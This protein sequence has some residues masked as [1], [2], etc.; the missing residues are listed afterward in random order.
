[1]PVPKIP[2][3]V[4]C[5][6]LNSDDRHFWLT[7]KVRKWQKQTREEWRKCKERSVVDMDGEFEETFILDFDGRSTVM[8]NYATYNATWMKGFFKNPF[9]I[10]WLN[11]DKYDVQMVTYAWV[12]LETMSEQVAMWELDDDT[13][14]SL[15]FICFKNFMESLRLL[16]EYV[17]PLRVIPLNLTR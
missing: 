1:M 6:I 3:P 8:P 2:S 7:M 9:D 4:S 15:T 17:V 13:R 10:D 14:S 5:T 16:Y 11:Y 12:A